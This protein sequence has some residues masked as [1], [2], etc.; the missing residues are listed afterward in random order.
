[1]TLSEA[2]GDCVFA[3]NKSST[4]E[5][6]SC[7][8]DAAAESKHEPSRTFACHMRIYYTGD[9]TDDCHPLCTW[10]MESSHASVLETQT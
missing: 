8:A 9:Y 10:Q 1:M 5:C 7:T 4:A 6:L 3:Q 2:D